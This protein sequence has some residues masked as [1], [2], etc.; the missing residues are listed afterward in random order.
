M[1][2]TLWLQTITGGE[3]A[4]FIG[5]KFSTSFVNDGFHSFKPRLLCFKNPNRR[6]TGFNEVLLPGE[7]KNRLFIV[8]PHRH[9]E[10]FKRGVNMEI[11]FLK[12]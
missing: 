1:Q 7:I 10:A 12:Q 6:T 4:K 11:A 5:S 9:C 8:T 2:R 3:I